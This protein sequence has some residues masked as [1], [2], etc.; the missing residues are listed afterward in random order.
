MMTLVVCAAAPVKIGGQAVIEGVMMKAPHAYA[1]ALRNTNTGAVEVQV[2]PTPQ[3]EKK[4]PRSWPFVRGIF[5]LFGLLWVGMKTLLISAD[6]AMALEKE[7]ADA[8]KAAAAPAAAPGAGGSPA[9][10]APAPSPA[11][12]PAKKGISSWEAGITIT[13]AVAFAIVLF[14]LLPLGFTEIVHR[15]MT[16]DT[17][18]YNAI[19]GVFRVLIFL[20]YLGAIGFIP[21][22]RRV[23][24]YHGA[25]HKAIHTYEHGQPLTVAA[26]RAHGTAH[27]RC[28]TNFLFIV[29]VISIIVFALAASDNW[30]WKILSRIVL[31]PVIIGV[32][33]EILKLADKLGTLGGLLA[34]PGMWLQRL[35]TREP[36]AAQVEVAL[37]ALRAVAETA[38]PAAVEATLP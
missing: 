4:G 13:A 36:D 12:A 5:E 37:A 10:A 38:P 29:I 28:G 18:A 15:K 3:R 27:R 24:A 20:A 23:F 17:L 6:R 25:E 32:S 30:A 19:D 16:L 26:T 9:A 22:I 7:K 1:L 34:A 21:D 14:V 11:A 31:M 35:T 8:A 33:Y 2:F